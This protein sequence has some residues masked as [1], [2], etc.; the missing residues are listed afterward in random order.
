MNDYEGERPDTVE[1]RR[2]QRDESSEE[3][4]ERRNETGEG[5]PRE[6]A[7]KVSLILISI[8]WC[9]VYLTTTTRR[10]GTR[11]RLRRLSFSSPSRRT[12]AGI[13]R[14]RCFIQ[15]HCGPLPGQKRAAALPPAV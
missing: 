11:E 8:S 3:E 1:Q 10:G 6:Q 9:D 13:P 2:E 12:Q 7:A 15:G 14:E 4:E 5:E